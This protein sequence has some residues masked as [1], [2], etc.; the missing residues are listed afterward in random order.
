MSQWHR[1][2]H[3]SLRWGLA[4]KRWNFLFLSIISQLETAHLL[5]PTLGRLLAA[6]ART[7]RSKKMFFFSSILVKYYTY[8]LLGNINQ[9]SIIFLHKLS[10]IKISLFMLSI[11]INTF[12]LYEYYK[13]MRYISLSYMIKKNTC[14][15]CCCCC[16]CWLQ[17]TCNISE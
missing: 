3:S 2:T 13:Q 17:L 14:W 6:L 5:L 11:M 10:I 9:L 12:L 4:G 1:L 15:C 16:C 8:S 7:S